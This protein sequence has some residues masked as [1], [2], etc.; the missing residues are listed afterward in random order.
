MVPDRLSQLV[1]R[2]S[3]VALEGRVLQT[4][5]VGGGVSRGAL[6]WESTLPPS[7]YTTLPDTGRCLTRFTF[8]LLTAVHEPMQLRLNVKACNALDLLV[9][10][11]A[12]AP[13]A[14]DRIPT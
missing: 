5:A 4:M 14:V 10:L 9:S 12:A 8:D 13:P 3:D 7:F 2:S 1:G 6:R 11:P